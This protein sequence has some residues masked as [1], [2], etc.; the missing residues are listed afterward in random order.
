MRAVRRQLAVGAI[1]LVAASLFTRSSSIMLDCHRVGR[2]YFEAGA[3]TDT[4]QA[5]A[6]RPTGVDDADTLSS[7]TPFSSGGQLSR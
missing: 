3:G 7:A 5:D 6:K 4:R 2:R 1:S